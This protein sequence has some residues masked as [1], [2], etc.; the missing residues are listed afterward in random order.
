MLVKARGSLLTPLSVKHDRVASLRV[1]NCPA[2]EAEW[3]EI[4]QHVL[5]QQPIPDI[6]ASA[7]VQADSS[8]SVTIRKQ[9]QGITVS[10]KL[11]NHHVQMLC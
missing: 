4:L 7:I 6:Y 2:S 1:K 9:I 3:E 11:S 5:R 10:V 8:I